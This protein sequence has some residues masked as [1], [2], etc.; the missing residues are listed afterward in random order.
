MKRILLLYLAFAV[1]FL[2]SGT[3]SNAAPKCKDGFQLVAG[4]WIGTPY[5][6]DKLLAQLS[7]YS[8]KTIRNDP[9]ARFSACQMYGR[10]PLIASI[11]G[12]DSVPLI[13]SR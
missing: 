12:I 13:P 6:G 9:S 7:G 1:G 11:C 4:K 8:F 3:T 5:C 2:S 10:D